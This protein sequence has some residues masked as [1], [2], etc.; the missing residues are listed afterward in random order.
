[1]KGAHTFLLTS[2][3]SGSAALASGVIC[4]EGGASVAISI[5]AR[6]CHLMDE[7]SIETMKQYSEQ[8][9]YAEP[10]PACLSEPQPLSHTPLRYRTPAAFP[11][12]PCSH[13]SRRIFIALFHAGPR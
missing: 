8:I 13:V 12:S 6:P 7:Q 3:A 10:G 2:S 1:M 4:S 9:V 5:S 11:P